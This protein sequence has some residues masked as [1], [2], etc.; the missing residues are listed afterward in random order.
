MI[1]AWSRIKIGRELNIPILLL[2]ISTTNNTNRFSIFQSFEYRYPH[3]STILKRKKSQN[4]SSN[5]P[6][7]CFIPKNNRVWIIARIYSRDR[8][9]IGVRNTCLSLSLSRERGWSRMIRI[10]WRFARGIG[11]PSWLEI[12]RK[13]TIESRPLLFPHFLP[14]SPSSLF[15]A[16]R[17]RY[18]V[19]KRCNPLRNREN[20]RVPLCVPFLPWH[21]N[22]WEFS[23][24]LLRGKGKT[25]EET[26]RNPRPL[27][28]TLAEL[29][30]EM[31]ILHC[32]VIFPVE[33]VKKE[34]D[35][36]VPRG[37]NKSTKLAEYFRQL[38]IGR[39]SFPS[40][41]VV[42]STR[43]SSYWPR[44]LKLVFRCA[45]IESGKYIYIYLK[46]L[47]GCFECYCFK[48][49]MYREG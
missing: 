9:L 29:L 27:S 38:I 17:P 1:D 8:I 4:S 36:F 40:F 11:Y 2:R 3:I 34:R 39:A 13:A 42:L 35:R 25:K 32:H 7:P 21:R 16:N 24:V 33:L 18:A 23:V 19:V 28:T 47:E 41:G 30:V 43:V 15:R 31:A 6:P 22:I 12:Q 46:W 10:F 44:Y 37:R 26:K 48:F 20:V 49:E 5:N 14:S 45:G